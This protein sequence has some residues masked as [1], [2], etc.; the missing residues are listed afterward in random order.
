MFV[1]THARSLS[2]Y[3]IS[4][5]SQSLVGKYRSADGWLHDDST[6]GTQRYKNKDKLQESEKE[7]L[8]TKCPNCDLT[9]SWRRLEGYCAS[10]GWGKKEQSKDDD[11]QIGGA[12]CAVLGMFTVCPL[13]GMGIG[14]AAWGFGGSLAGGGIGI[15]IPIGFIVFALVSATSS[16]TK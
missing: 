8:H 16:R 1:I 10:C 13:V 6:E 14:Y 3:L 5:R 7:K 15:A 9:S 2:G 11:A 4:E 12:C